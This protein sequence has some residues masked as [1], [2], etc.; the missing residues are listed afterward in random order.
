MYQFYFFFTTNVSFFEFL[1]L[2]TV[3]TV[4]YTRIESCLNVAA[5]ASFISRAFLDLTLSFLHFIFLRDQGVRSAW[6]LSV[7]IYNPCVTFYLRVCLSISIYPNNRMKIW[8]LFLQISSANHK[9]YSLLYIHPIKLYIAYILN[10]F[11]SIC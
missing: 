3:V 10:E 6:I 9:N 5:C 8:N 2:F 11:D 1:K 4:L 7:S